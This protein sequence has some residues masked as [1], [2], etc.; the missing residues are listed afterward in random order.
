MSKEISSP[1]AQFRDFKAL[2]VTDIS[3]LSWCEQQ[4]HY[5]LHA[6]GRTETTEMKAGSDIHLKLELEVHDLV[7][8][9]IET[10]EDLWGLKLFNLLFGLEALRTTGETRELPVFGF[11]SDIFVFGIIDQIKKFPN[12]GIRKNNDWEW[13]ICDTKTRSKCFRPKKSTVPSSV[14]YQI[15]LYKKLF[16]NLVESSIEEERIFEVLDLDADKS[17]SKK[18]S[19]Y[20]KIYFSNFKKLNTLR[21]LMAFIKNYF[22]FFWK[23]NNVLEVNYKYQ[24]DGSD[25]GSL[26]FEYEEDMLDKHLKRSIIYWKGDREPEGVPIEEAWKC[27]ICE[28]VE[29]CEWRLK[30]VREIEQR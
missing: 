11:V 10:S 17:F 4:F 2:Y 27:Q 14:K 16:D 3:S 5:S 30:K 1:Y 18:F 7:K 12:Q 25:L 15:M 19:K 9:S 28:Y 6:G 8:V 13:R 23:S 26:Y 20:I 21:K 22:G 24:G 29:N